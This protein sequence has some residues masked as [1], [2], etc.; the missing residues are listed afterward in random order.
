VSR[1]EVQGAFAEPTINCCGP[2]LEHPVGDV[3]L[4][5]FA[6]LTASLSGAGCGRG[7]PLGYCLQPICLDAKSG[8]FSA[9]RDEEISHNREDGDI[10]LQG[11]Y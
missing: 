10:T 7:F 2:G 1:C 6:R 5:D 3:T 4:S 11:S 8:A 9:R